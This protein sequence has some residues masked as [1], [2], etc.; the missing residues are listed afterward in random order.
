MVLDLFPHSARNRQPAA[1]K[2]RDDPPAL[3]AA[4]QVTWLTQQPL[5]FAT[6][7][8]K[9]AG[10]APTSAVPQMP[11]RLGSLRVVI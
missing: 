8:Q 11:S 1:S 4:D 6:V 7:R 10:N 3:G 2:M 5:T 9:H